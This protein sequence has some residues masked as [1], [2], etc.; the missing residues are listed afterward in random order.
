MR[1]SYSRI[2]AY[3]VTELQHIVGKP[4]VIVDDAEQLERYSHD[5]IKDPHYAHLPEVVVKPHTAEEISAILKLANREC[6]PV[7]P[8]GA[9]SGGNQ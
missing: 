5:E 7:T 1:T 6:I 2:T 3:I 8:R 4:H 9:G